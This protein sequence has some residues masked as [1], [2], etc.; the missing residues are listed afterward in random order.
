MDAQTH[1]IARVAIPGIKNDQ[2]FVAILNQGNLLEISGESPIMEKSFQ[3][4][5]IV[6]N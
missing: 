2:V 6:S 5:V 4:E 3:R 1:L